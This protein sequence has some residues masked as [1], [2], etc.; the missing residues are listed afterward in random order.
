[1]LGLMLVKSKRPSVTL[2]VLFYA[3]VLFLT[4]SKTQNAPIG[5]GFA[6]LGLRFIALDKEKR[7]RKLII[8]LSAITALA[9]VA[10]YVAAPKDF[11]HINMYQTVFFGILNESPDVDGDLQE[12]G[13]P[14]RLSVLA[15]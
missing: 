14:Q 5:I 10:M 15:G 13:L 9:S 7:L 3:A 1:G 12:L 2:L 8:G 11:K 4:C 6:L